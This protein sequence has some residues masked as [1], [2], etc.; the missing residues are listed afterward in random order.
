MARVTI[1]SLDAL[2]QLAAVLLPMPRREADQRAQDKPREE[3]VDEPPSDGQERQGG[4]SC[5][6][7][8]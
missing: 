6:P 7:S 3:M 8:A 5:A 4:S 2:D 1:A